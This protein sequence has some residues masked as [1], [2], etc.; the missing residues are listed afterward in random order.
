MIVIVILTFAAAGVLSYSLTTYQNSV[1]QARLDQA[2]E[3][4]DSEMEYLYYCWKTMLLAKYPV[5]SLSSL[6]SAGLPNPSSVLVN[7]PANSPVGTSPITGVNM[8]TAE[9]PFAS[10]E[11]VVAQNGATWSISRMLVF[12]PM[13]TSDGSA[14]GIVPGTLQIG[15]NFYFSAETSATYADPILGNLTY[16]SGRHFV[17]SSTSLFQ[18]AVFY[19]GNIEIAA[20]GNMVIGGPMST[21]ASA[22]MGSQSGYTLTITDMAYYFQNFNGASDPLSGETDRLEGSGALS[23]PVYNPNPQAAAPG[24]QTGQRALQVDKLASQSSFIGGVDVASDIVNYAAAYSNLQN[25]PD[26]NEVYRA[27]IAPPPQ[28][29]NSPGTLLPEDPV[30]AASRM[31]NS[32]ALL[33]TINQNGSGTP[34]VDIG[35]A[36]NPTAYDST[37][38]ANLTS[39]ANPIIT[40]VRQSITD[41]REELNGASGVNLSTL[42]VGHLNSALT[43]PGGALSTNSSLAA[44]YNGVVYVYDNTNNNAPGSTVPN[45]LNGIRIANATTTPNVSDQNGDP[46]GFSVVSNNGV[47]V[48]GDY[49]TTPITVPTGQVNNP[50]AIMGDAIT[51]LSQGWTP[52]EATST[53][54]IEPAGSLPG[55]LATASQPTAASSDGVNPASAGTPNGMTVNAAIL[56]GNTPSTTTTNSGGVQNLVRLV[57]DW[58]DPDPTGNGT[59]MAL[60]LDG[61][62]GQLFTSKYFNSKYTGN[63]IQAALPSAGDRVYIQ[64]RTRNF[65]Y[66]V[67]FK[68]RVPAGSPTTTNFARGDFFFW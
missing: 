61:S 4:A 42:D 6:T 10:N 27:V 3:V 39:G 65:D 33:I 56:T 18:F 48:Q 14:Q 54:A 5:A 59:G 36:A 19:Q 29:P 63:G 46:I 17:Y 60:T 16:H 62:L 30:V 53:N 43:G 57:E 37:F 35:T 11:L 26:P 13:G 55:R 15:H 25:I 64:P 21:N 68:A 7:P 1:R 44:A 20:G 8:T 41:P 45:S 23:D 28:D 9:V 32:A 49:N 66:D 40:G 24:D 22:Y 58:Y 52:A 12:N 34:T 67:G 47:Y 38:A 51:A 31:Y 50:S 2:K